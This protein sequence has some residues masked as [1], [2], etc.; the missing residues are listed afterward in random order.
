M[1]RPTI[2]ER[3]GKSIEEIRENAAREFQ[4]AEDLILV[5]L[6]EEAK[7]GFLGF[8]SAPAQA[9]VTIIPD[10]REIAS[11][12]LSELLVKLNDEARVQASDED[13]RYILS[14]EGPDV[15]NIIGKR[16]QTLNALQY[17][18]NVVANRW[19]GGNRLTVEVDVEGYR[20]CRNESLR[21]LSERLAEKVLKSRKAIELEPM[22]AQ[23][24]RIVHMTLK[25]INGI[26]TRSEGDDPNRRVII[27]CGNAEGGQ[28]A[29]SDDQKPR[30][31]RR[32]RPRR[33][34]E[35]VVA[36]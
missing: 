10:R 20:E 3:K 32:R 24:R 23:E 34:K 31:R 26:E 36:E 33:R 1:K 2:V 21:E 8:G 35:E 22:S 27:T 4:V 13:D 11:E 5:E 19:K 29:A 6:K 18:V 16:G 25:E 14:I 15:G 30:S 9:Q 12:F 17:L 7:D 28:E